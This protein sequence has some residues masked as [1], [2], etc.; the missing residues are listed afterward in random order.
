MNY[1]NCKTC[2]IEVASPSYKPRKY[3]SKTCYGKNNCGDINPSKRPEVIQKIKDSKLGENNWMYGRTENLCPNWKGDNASYHSKHSWVRRMFGRPGNCEHCDKTGLKCREIQWA[4]ISGK[5]LRVRQD[6]KRL[7][8]SCH[9]IF[10]KHHL[11]LKRD[12]NGR[13][14]FK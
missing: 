5:Y 1:I 4:N 2:G 11:K 8:T 10:D 7:C 3:C 6:W 12:S 13:F 9:R 14:M